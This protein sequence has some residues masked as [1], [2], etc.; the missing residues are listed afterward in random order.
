MDSAEVLNRILSS[1]CPADIDTDTGFNTYRISLHCAEF[2]VE[3]YI[4]RRVYIEGEYDY[5]EFEVRDLTPVAG[6][7]MVSP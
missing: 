2:D 1:A 4:K 3:A 6:H 7:A 5:T